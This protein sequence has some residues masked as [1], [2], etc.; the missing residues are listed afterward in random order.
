MAVPGRSEESAGVANLFVE[1]VHIPR[2]MK[3][4][5]IELA[6]VADP[7]LHHFGKAESGSA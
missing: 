5:T 4:F 6:S 1:S 3:I 2:I 7:D